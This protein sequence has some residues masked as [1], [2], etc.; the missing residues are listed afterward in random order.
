MGGLSMHP[1]PQVPPAGQ[2]FF[3]AHNQPTALFETFFNA[4][5]A[6]LDR[7]IAP[8]N[9]GYWEPSKI[10]ASHENGSTVETLE[11][12]YERI[13]VEY[14]NAVVQG[15]APPQVFK[16]PSAAT[17]AFIPSAMRQML[18]VQ[19]GELRKQPIL[20]RTGARSLMIFYFLAAPADCYSELVAT[21]HRYHILLPFQLERSMVPLAPVP[22]WRERLTRIQQD[23]ANEMLQETQAK[24]MMEKRGRE[25][26]LRLLDPPGTRYVYNYNSNLDLI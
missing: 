24:V 4:Y 14:I 1:P 11:W 8:A 7:S 21:L 23:I 18:D 16:P 12:L 2:T 25:A 20:T 22:A 3:D 5:F 19:L 10:L 13:P 9:T 26:S 15:P 6:G 17:M